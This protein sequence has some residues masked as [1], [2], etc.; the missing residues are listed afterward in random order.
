[1]KFIFW[2]PQ[3]LIA[4]SISC[5]WLSLYSCLLSHQTTVIINPYDHDGGKICDVKQ[6]KKKV[7]WW[8]IT[9]KYWSDLC[10]SLQFLFSWGAFSLPTSLLD[11]F[12][13]FFLF[14]SDSSW[15]SGTTRGWL[16]ELE[17][18]N[19]SVL[20]TGATPVAAIRAL[21]NSR[22]FLRQTRR[23]FCFFL[24]NTYWFFGWTSY[25]YMCVCILLSTQC[26][27]TLRRVLFPLQRF[28]RTEWTKLRGAMM[29][30]TGKWP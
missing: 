6:K 17:K 9:R 29:R 23:K 14:F 25:I 8:A 10:A 7:S 13:G 27:R 15:L 11:V 16:G 26:I 3:P 21:T 1:M 5:Q 20:V 22:S 30:S 19:T 24:L 18:G 28:E 2:L 4:S 12:F